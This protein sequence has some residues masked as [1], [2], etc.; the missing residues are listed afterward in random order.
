[1]DI[2]YQ[3]EQVMLRDSVRK[4]VEQDYDFDT[5]RRIIQ[6]ERGTSTEH[7]SLFAELGWLTIPFSEEDG[8][9]GGSAIDIAIVMEEFGRGLIIEPY[10]ASIVLAGGLLARLANAEQKSCLLEPLMAGELRLALAFNEP[11]SRY[12]LSNVRTTAVK[13]G[14]GYVISGH[15]SVVQH[16]DS[17]DTFIVVARSF[18]EQ[19]DKQGISLFLIDRDNAGIRH[20]DYQTVDGHRATELYLDEVAVSAAAL[21]GEEGGAYTA[22]SQAIDRAALAACAEAVGAMEAALW[23]TVAYTQQRKQFGVP[24]ATFQ[25]LRHRMAEMYIE[26]EQARSITLMANLTLDANAKNSARAVS[27]AKYRVGRAARL[28]G[29]EAVQMHGAIG[30][31]DEADIG[32]Y[33]K[34]LTAIQ[35]SF[36]SGDYHKLRYIDLSS[37]VT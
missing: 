13:Q 27:A 28:V 1:M 33:L 24:I 19:R 6:S 32:H 10:L 3:E 29:E 18:G 12:C 17:A 35:Y 5:R 15:K 4:F 23:K 16:G 34:R 31:T 37:R 11:Q 14:E 7:W 30:V 9:F 21:L 26:C 20:R 2:R 25:A 22:L 36:G 8:G